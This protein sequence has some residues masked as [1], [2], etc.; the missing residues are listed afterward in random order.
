[1]PVQNTDISIF[2]NLSFIWL[3]TSLHF[4]ALVTSSGNENI[5]EFNLDIS[6]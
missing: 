1:M 5:F 6:F 3:N 2:P 4:S